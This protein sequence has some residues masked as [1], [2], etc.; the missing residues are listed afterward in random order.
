LTADIQLRCASTSEN[1]AIVRELLEGVGD[2]LLLERGLRDD[3][4]TAASEACNN[5]VM[6]AYGDA[7]GPMEIHVTVDARS[8]EVVVRDEGDGISAR[9]GP[10]DDT[11]PGI[12]L[13]VIQSFA[14]TMELN[15]RAGTGIEVRMRFAIV[16]SPMPLHEASVPFVDFPDGPRHR[17]VM[18]SVVGGPLVGPVLAR[19][20]AMMAVQARF[21]LDRLSDAQLVGDLVAARVSAVVARGRVEVAFEIAPRELELRVG[22]LRSGAGSQLLGPAG[23]LEPVIG[24]LVDELDVLAGPSGELLVARMTD[25][26]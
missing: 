4:K 3:I 17:D 15:E 9:P 22:P 8:L 24:R 20:L 12:G 5:V 1:V 23:G 21:T 7:A 25:Q 18:L 14:D 6:H 26:R 19:V 2:A 10:H 16:G 13:A 11:M